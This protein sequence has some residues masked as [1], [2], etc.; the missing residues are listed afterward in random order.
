VRFFLP[1][2]WIDEIKVCHL[3]AFLCKKRAQKPVTK[4]LFI[5]MLVFRVKFF[6][7]ADCAWRLE[8]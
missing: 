3:V 6:H 2:V 4:A 5:L 1:V 7:I 8:Q